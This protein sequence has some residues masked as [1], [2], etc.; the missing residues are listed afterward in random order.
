MSP[1]TAGIIVTCEHAG[2]TAPKRYQHLFKDHDDRLNSHRGY[3]MGALSLARKISRTLNAPLFYTK[4]TRL[5]IEANRSPYSRNLFSPITR[6]LPG[7]DR[8]HIIQRFYRPYRSRVEQALQRMTTKRPMVHLSIHTFT[9]ILDGKVRQADIGILYDPGRSMEKEIS[10]QLF[11]AFQ[12]TNPLE[13]TV[14]RN[15]P[16]KGVADSFT[17][18]LRKRYADNQY[19]GLEIEVNQKYYTAGPKTWNR[20]GRYVAGVMRTV[21]IDR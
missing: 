1:D 4:Y 10:R 16:Y 11:T 9:P 2:N 19:A 20:V 14:R 5:L 17:T 18:S 13:L 15:Y 12:R 21:C 7:S 3:D 6:E 8:E